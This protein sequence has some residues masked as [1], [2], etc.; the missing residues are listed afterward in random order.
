MT[1]I[2]VIK[3]D[4]TE[5]SFDISK[6][7]KQI[8]FACE[9]TKV[10]PLEFES[11]IQLEIKNKT[12]TSDIQ[13]VIINTAV[14][15]ITLDTPEWNLVAG[16]AAMYQLYR[17]VYK[18]TKKDVQ[19]WKEL[20]QYLVHNGYY[21]KD[22]L[23]YLDNLS[24]R[25]VKYLDKLVSSY[26]A[27]NYDFSMVFSQVKVLES[28][29]LIKNKRGVIE[30]PVVSDIVNTL[31]LTQGGEYFKEVF[32]AI[33]FQ[34]ISLATP[35]KRNLR[36]PNGNTVS[37][38]I[39]ENI[40]SL[41]GI[42]KAITDMSFI[43]KEGGG[44]GWYWGKVR[45]S[46]SSSYRIPQANEIN[47]W[48]KFANDVAVAVDQAGTRK[49]AI[50][51]AVDWW[52][53]DIEMFLEMK[54]LVKGEERLKCLDLFPQFVVDDYF[55]DA[56]LDNRDIYLYDHYEVKKKYNIDITELVDDEL[57]RAHEMLQELAK[58]KKIKARKVNAKKLWKKALILWIEVGDAYITHKDNLNLSNYMK[59]DENGGITKCTNLCV[60]SFSFT[61]APTK[62]LERGEDSYRETLETNGRYHSCNLI[63][64][65]VA[66]LA[67]LPE[68]KLNEKLNEICFA[69]VYTLDRS[70]DEGVPPVLEA[71][72]NQ[73]ELR[74]IGIG[75]VGG[76]DYVAWKKYTYDS[77]EGQKELEKLVEKIAYY[78][79]K[80]SVELASNYGSYPKF[81]P[82]NYDK[83]IGKDP[84]DLDS[85]SKELG[86]NFDWTKLAEDIR[87][88]GIRNFLLLAVAPNTTSG[89][90]Q[91][92]TASYL[93][94]QAKLFYQTLSDMSVPILPPFIKERY[95]YYKTKF[96]YHPRTIIEFTRKIQRWID[97]GISMEININPEIC[98][99]NEISDAILEGFKKKEL[100]A[101]YYSLTI[102][103]DKKKARP[104]CEDCAN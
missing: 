27:K 85:R 97:T 56:V 31:I 101:V 92:A 43:S 82:K 100:K 7:R 38:F 42:M 29:Y 61:K 52:H 81:N 57:Y 79:Y 102:G 72:L 90:V 89:I 16:R 63:S 26:D 74:N 68:D 87:K 49:G 10:N 53:P 32:D 58:Q 45:S 47:L 3:R 65:N 12:K 60:E 37:C 62:W 93:P 39:G 54:S 2:V 23:K 99:I 55:V 22:I 95:W 66:Q 1:D 35:F 78:S 30:Y 80:A 33:H 73:E 20:I 5:Q 40:D 86:N 103:K 75:M 41:A 70:I 59:F 17:Q 104:K 34:Y 19:E 11:K 6:I 36:R 21:R 64:L 69:A 94:A 4:G 76:A 67:K 71:K 50:T 9:S 77:E 24:S 51:V 25:D 83:L 18:N 14:K 98:R 13:E 15:N 88:N 8:E 46:L 48:L 44:V 91:G 96:Q 28:K 84:K